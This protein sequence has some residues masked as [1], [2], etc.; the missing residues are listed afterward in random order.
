MNK[1]TGG[2]AF[3]QNTKIVAAAGQELHHGFMGGMTLRDYFAAKAM[4]AWMTGWATDRPSMLQADVMADKAYEAA[5]AM[6]KARE[7]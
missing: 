6:L 7:G 2:P 4:Q 1:D 5:D 3:P